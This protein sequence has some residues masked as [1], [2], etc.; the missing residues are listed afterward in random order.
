MEIIIGKG[1]IRKIG[2]PKFGVYSQII[3]WSHE[4]NVTFSMV[5][6]CVT[7]LMKRGDKCILK[8]N[9]KRTMHNKMMIY[10]EVQQGC[11]MSTKNK[12]PLI[13]QKKSFSWQALG[14]MKE[15]KHI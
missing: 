1:T 10:K 13:M 7:H 6:T 3:N 11:N 8:I 2:Q 9:T 15:N 14:K 12:N 4:Q 5:R